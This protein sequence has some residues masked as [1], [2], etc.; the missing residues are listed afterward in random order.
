MTYIGKNQ[1]LKN[2]IE[3]KSTMT[4]DIV[5]MLRREYDYFNNDGVGDYE[6]ITTA[7]DEIERLR[8]DRDKWRDI[9]TELATDLAIE[10]QSTPKK[11]FKNTWDKIQRCGLTDFE[12]AVRGE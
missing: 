10:Y 5:T 4:D 9:A 3:K 1:T 6:V 8:A 12:K 11:I 7:A 2:D